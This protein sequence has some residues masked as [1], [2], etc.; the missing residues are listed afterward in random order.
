MYKKNS[1][2]PAQDL[3]E[4]YLGELKKLGLEAKLE[5]PIP[6]REI[7]AFL[8]FGLESVSNLKDETGRKLSGII[9]PEERFIR[10]EAREVLGRQN[11]TIAHEIGH[12]R[13]HIFGSTLGNR[14]P[15][16]FDSVTESATAFYR[17]TDNDI[18]ENKSQ[19]EENKERLERNTHKKQEQQANRFAAEILMPEDLVRIWHKQLHGDLQR[20][21]NQFEVSAQAMGYRLQSIHL[22]QENDVRQPRIA[23]WQD[24][25]D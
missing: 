16:L 17:C 11:F 19:H 14:N 6:I 15:T 12:A 18:A 21:A 24:H 13:L 4:W 5:P 8:D 10:F 22:T 3:L 7:A 25:H 23:F 2:T 20:L 9:V 1:G